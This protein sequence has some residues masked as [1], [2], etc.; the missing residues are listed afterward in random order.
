MEVDFGLYKFLSNDDA[1]DSEAEVVDNWQD[2]PNQSGSSSP[3]V[4]STPVGS[5]SRF[6][7]NVL[8]DL[9]SLMWILCYF[10]ASREVFV[11]GEPRG[12]SKEQ[13][14]WSCD[15]FFCAETLIYRHNLLTSDGEYALFTESLHPSVQFVAQH[16]KIMRA[17]LVK[18][19][20]KLE[21]NPARID[22]TVGNKLAE[23]FTRRLERAAKQSQ[24]RGIDLS[25]RVTFSRRLEEFADFFAQRAENAHAATG[26]GNPAAV[27]HA[28]QPALTTNGTVT[29]TGTTTTLGNSITVLNTVTTNAV[30]TNAATTNAA[31]ASAVPNKRK[32]GDTNSA[33]RV[34]KK[35]LNMLLPLVGRKR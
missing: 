17:Q 10:L 33:P 21:K 20:T 1:I 18:A 9:E 14:G 30:T 35:I 28:T 27:Q 4:A 3:S 8:H 24:D 5:H 11:N 16:L 12:V 25:L 26:A 6:R 19:Y 32:S 34:R 13:R 29:L 7:Y 15:L 22:N 23:S 2:R 31:T